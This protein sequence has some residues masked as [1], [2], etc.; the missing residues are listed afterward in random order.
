MIFGLSIGYFIFSE[1]VS[2]NA[3]IGCVLIVLSSFTV[4][5]RGRKMIG[6]VGLLISNLVKSIVDYTAAHTLKFYSLF[7]VRLGGPL[8]SQLILRMSQRRIP[9]FVVI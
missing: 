2:I 6:S 4:L 5:Y 9:A 1:H 8:P 3:A 7:E